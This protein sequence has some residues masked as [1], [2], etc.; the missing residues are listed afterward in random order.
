MTSDLSSALEVYI[1]EMRYTT[2]RTLYFTLLYM[3]ANISHS[4]NANL[5]IAHLI[6]SLRNLSKAFSKYKKAKTELLFFS[7]KLLL[8]LSYNK[9]G[10]S[11]SFTF[12]KN[13]IAYHLYE[14]AAK[15]SVRRSFPPLS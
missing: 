4:S 8:H 3:T 11:G 6:T 12:F 13:Q 10:V 2:R 14:S 5:H 9:N 7:S 15:F 1:N